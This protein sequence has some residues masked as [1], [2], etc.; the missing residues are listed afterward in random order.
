MRAAPAR[1]IR[2]VIRSVAAIFLAACVWLAPIVPLS[3][4][5]GASHATIG[6][7]H[8][9]S[10]DALR[11]AP[12]Q[13]AAATALEF[14]ERGHTGELDAAAVAASARLPVAPH[15]RLPCG[16]QPCPAFDPA[17]GHPFFDATAPP[18]A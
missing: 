4:T 11:P 6:A 9:L 13:A 7:D 16:A 15:R 12:G 2:C 18:L 1:Y 3:G 5:A 10:D 14:R 8:R 17:G